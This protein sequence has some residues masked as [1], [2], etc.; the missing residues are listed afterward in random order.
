MTSESLP[1][2]SYRPPREGLLSKLPT[3]LNNYYR[4]SVKKQGLQL[5]PGE[6]APVLSNPLSREFIDND[7]SSTFLV[8]STSKA[9]AQKIL[10]EGLGL[11]GQR[12]DPDAPD[13]FEATKM[14][15]PQKGDDSKDATN[16]NIHGLAYRYDSGDFGQNS[17]YK[18]VAELAMPNPGTSL[19]RNPFEHTALEHPDGSNVVKHE[20]EDT[21]S[22]GKPFSIPPERIRGY[23]DIETGEFT[24][25][26]RFEA[27]A[28]AIGQVAV[29][30]QIE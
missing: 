27:V 28:K 13:L 9:V 16:R 29:D 30:Q 18:V 19:N 12:Y 22:H 20:K 15:A 7:G 23:F 8:H 24:H 21:P 10:Q 14:L 6:E 11:N 2:L 1:P 3:K 4:H 26:E 25:N 5:V 17:G